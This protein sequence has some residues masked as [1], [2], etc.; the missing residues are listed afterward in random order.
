MSPGRLV[1][2]DQI[3]DYTWGRAHTFYEDETEDISHIDFSQPYCDTL[4]KKLIHASQNTDLDVVTHGIYGATQGPRLETTA[5]INRMEK[6]GCDIVGMTGMPEAALARE[7]G[8]NYASIAI[9]ANWAAGKSEQELTMD[10]IMKNLDKGISKV[11]MLLEASIP[12]I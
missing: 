4:R 12:E 5:E 7:L 2:P 6:D 11:T 8:L 1:I 9:I 3:I 10:M